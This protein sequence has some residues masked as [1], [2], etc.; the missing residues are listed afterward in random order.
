MFR[1][2]KFKQMKRKPKYLCVKNVLI[3]SKWNTP[4]DNEVWNVNFYD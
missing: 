4:A 2:M 3:L 1:L